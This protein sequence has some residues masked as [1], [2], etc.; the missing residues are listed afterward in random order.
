M[1]FRLHSNVMLSHVNV[2]FIGEMNEA[3]ER[4]HYTE[5]AQWRRNGGRMKRQTQKREQP[6]RE[7]SARSACPKLKVRPANS[8]G[9]C[10]FLARLLPLTY[11]VPQDWHN[12]LEYFF[13]FRHENTCCFGPRFWHTLYGWNPYQFSQCHIIASAQQSLLMWVS[14]LSLPLTKQQPPYIF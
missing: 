4:Q 1:L 9:D 6:Q 10:W 5:Q 2:F 7:K 12:F 8:T 3:R 14:R 13:A 11:A